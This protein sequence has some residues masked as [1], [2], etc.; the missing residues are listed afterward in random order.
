[1]LQEGWRDSSNERSRKM[2]IEKKLLGWTRLE[3]L[4]MFTR[5]V[6]VEGWTRKLG[7]SELGTECRVKS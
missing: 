7:R 3:S 6:S 5:Q 1:M 2:I 4:V